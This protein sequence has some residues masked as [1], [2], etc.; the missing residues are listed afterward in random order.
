MLLFELLNGHSPFE[1]AEP[2]KTYEKILAGRVKYPAR[3]ARRAVDLCSRLLEADTSK[4]YGNL[5]A[6]ADD[7]RR[8]RFYRS[9]DFAWADALS[10]RW[11]ALA[12][13]RL[14]TPCPRACVHTLPASPSR[15]CASSSHV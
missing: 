8:H 9:D 10:Y 15:A 7:I 1:A 2:L 4:R 5:V 14:P 3:M 11:C 13:D 12:R 6:G